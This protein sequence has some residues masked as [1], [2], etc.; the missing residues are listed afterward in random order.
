MADVVT[1]QTI[2]DTVGTKTVIKMTNISDGTGET[3]VTK[4][5][6]SA[7]NFSAKSAFDLVPT[8][9]S[10]IALERS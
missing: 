1:T 7:L 5:D 4:A 6:A 3:L 8:I 10:R 9:L 2:V